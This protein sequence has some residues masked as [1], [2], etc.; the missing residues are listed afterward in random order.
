M[1]DHL[2]KDLI[3][4]GGVIIYMDDILIHAKTSKELDKLTYQVLTKRRS[5]QNSDPTRLNRLEDFL[6]LSQSMDSPL[7]RGVQVIR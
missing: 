6:G 1:M 7:P 3:E 5:D 4:L 2:F